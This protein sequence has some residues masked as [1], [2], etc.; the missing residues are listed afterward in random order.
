MYLS[1]FVLINKN[2]KNIPRNEL[3]SDQ[4][5]F[6]VNSTMKLIMTEKQLSHSN[7]RFS[8]RWQPAI[9]N[10]LQNIKRT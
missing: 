2:K 5:N 1:Y 7:I 8:T 10:F 3:I 9:H 4:L 6:P